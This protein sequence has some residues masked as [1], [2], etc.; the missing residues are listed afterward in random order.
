[1]RLLKGDAFRW[2]Y[3]ERI[4]RS[5]EG[6]TLKSI[7]I[8]IELSLN[9]LLQSRASSYFRSPT[10]WTIAFATVIKPSHDRYA[11]VS[12]NY[13]MY[14]HI[15]SV[16]DNSATQQRVYI[17]FHNYL[18]LCM[19]L[20]QSILKSAERTPNTPVPAQVSRD[21]S[22]RL[23]TWI[24]V[25]SGIWLGNEKIKRSRNRIQRVQ[26]AKRCDFMDCICLII[27]RSP[28]CTL[29]VHCKHLTQLI[30]RIV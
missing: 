1:M 11:V 26:R 12:E 18:C 9:H 14:W 10:P 5:L 19:F 13:G 23:P 2:A 4:G 25:I 15:S 20:R 29:R 28:Y 30:K 8:T 27:P 7:C 24:L 17:V 6:L 16:S 3:R 21:K 22:S